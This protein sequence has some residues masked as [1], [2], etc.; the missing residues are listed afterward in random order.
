MS[1]PRVLIADDHTLTLGGICML[2]RPHYEIVGTVTN[3]RDLIDMALR[4]RPDVIIL[5]ITMPVLNGIDAARQIKQWMPEAKLLFLTMHVK[6][7]YLSSALQV[8]GT[9]YIL[10]S[11]ASEDLLLALQNVLNG[12]IHVSA[13][14]FNGN[15]DCFT[16]PAQAAE[17]LRLSSREREVLQLVAEGKSTKEIAFLLT[18]SARTVNF[19]RENIK[20]KL[21]LNSTAE[22]TKYALEQGLI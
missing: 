3:G 21:G 12:R 6:S 5:D 11:A 9:G 15:L 4:V 19:H 20:H 14:V 7:A 2:L 18:I 17:S 22:L 1:R 10:K 16:D 13:G 8:G